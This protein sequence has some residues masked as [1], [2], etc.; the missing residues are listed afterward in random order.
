MKISIVMAYHDRKELLTKTL[1]SLDNNEH[2]N[3]EVIVVDD[4]SSDKHRVEHL[5]K[6]FKFLKVFRIDPDK[7]TWM[8]PCIPNNIGFHLATGDVVV[9]QNPE[10]LHFGDIL[11]DIHSRWE[12]NKYLVYGCYALDQQKTNMLG[13]I[14]GNDMTSIKNLI[15]PTNDVH[16]DASVEMNRWYQHSKYSPRCFNFCTAIGKADLDALGGFD[17]AFAEGIGF[18]DTEFIDRVVKKGMDVIMFDTPTVIHQWHPYTNYSGKNWSLH[19]KNKDIYN[20]KTLKSSDFVAA[21]TKTKLIIE[22]LLSNE[23]C[24]TKQ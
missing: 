14:A 19:M 9:I 13:T 3:L 8:N 7:K 2:N 22:E 18:D 16:L 5:Q 20:N 24:F 4:A 6:I 15:E 23:N 12:P 1:E 10:C 17:D 21:N 11:S